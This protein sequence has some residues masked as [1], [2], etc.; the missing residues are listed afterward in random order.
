MLDGL[1]GL[2]RYPRLSGRSRSWRPA[3]GAGHRAPIAGAAGGVGARL[4]ELLRIRLPAPPAGRRVEH[5]PDAWLSG[6]GRSAKRRSFRARTPAAHGQAR[7]HCRRRSGR[8][9]RRVLSGARRACLFAVRRQRAAG[10]AAALRNARGHARQADRRSRNR[11]Y[12]ESGRGVSRRMAPGPRRDAG[13]VARRIW[14]RVPGFRRV[15]RLDQRKTLRRQ[16]LR[17]VA[18]FENRP[19][20]NRRR[21]PLAR[22]E[23]GGRIR[24]GRGDGRAFQCR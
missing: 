18:G 21:R 10:R 24:R 22:N 2:A 16:G 17:R 9:V 13:A 19:A 23:S 14:R 8:L 5:S 7:R 15:A 20:W 6:R 11:I 4:P 12:P 1:P 3:Q